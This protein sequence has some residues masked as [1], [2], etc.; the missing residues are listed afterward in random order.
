MRM[1][2]SA[3]VAVFGAVV[4]TALAIAPAPVQAATFE[5]AHSYTA[6]GR[7]VNLWRKTSG[8]VGL[9]GQIVRAQTNDQVWL[10]NIWNQSLGTYN[11]PQGA[12]EANTHSVGT[13]GSLFR[14]CGKAS[15]NIFCTGYRFA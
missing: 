7:T 4:G 1:R 9:H 3:A 11:V 14:A 15:N 5:L 8:G 10:E 13:S 2:K 12:T 6:Y